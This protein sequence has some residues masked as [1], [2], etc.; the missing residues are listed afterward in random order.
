MS[1][2]AYRQDRR[3]SEYNYHVPMSHVHLGNPR[4]V[5]PNAIT[6]V[7]MID[8]IASIGHIE[9]WKAIMAERMYISTQKLQRICYGKL[10]NQESRKEFLNQVKNLLDE[11]RAS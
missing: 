3:K 5:N 1:I 7:Q 11:K 6:D 9:D 10:T 2:P 4:A 8:A